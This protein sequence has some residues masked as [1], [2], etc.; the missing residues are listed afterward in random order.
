VLEVSVAEEVLGQSLAIENP[1]FW[2]AT[3]IATAENF[4]L[5][6]S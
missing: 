3:V 4:H 6:T 5:G 1:M 2:G